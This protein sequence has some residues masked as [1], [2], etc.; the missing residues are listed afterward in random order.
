MS[1]HIITHLPDPTG[2]SPDPLTDLLRSGARKL[3]EQ[4]VGAELDTLLA[5]HAGERIADGRV[6]PVRHGHLPASH[7]KDWRVSE[8]KDRPGHGLQ[9]DDVGAEEMEKARRLQPSARGHQGVEC[10]DG[11]RYVQVAA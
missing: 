4:A 10:R 3:I 7:R 6:R 9:T 11:I 2:F 8:P 5:A 1:E